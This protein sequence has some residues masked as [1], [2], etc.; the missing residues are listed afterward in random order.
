MKKL[1]LFM[2]ILFSL[3]NIF[4]KDLS[5]N[6]DFNSLEKYLEETVTANHVPG[7]AFVLTNSKNTLFAKTFGQCKNLDQQ[8]FLG[9]ESK[10]FTALCIMQLSEKKLLNLDDDISIYLPDYSFSK[11]VTVKSLLNQVSG[12]DTHM[13]LNN[14]KVTN[15]YGKYEYANINYDLLGKIIET[16][17]GTSYEDYIKKN[18]F[19]PLEMNG[20]IANAD[21]VKNSERLLTGNRNY[22][23]FFITGDA[24]YPTEKSWFHEPAGFITSTPNDYAK[25]LR[26][27]LNNGLSERNQIIA[28]ESSI[29]SMWYDNVEISKNEPARYGMGWNCL[30]ENGT[31]F[32]SHGGQVENY[33][34]Y[35]LVIPQR[36]LAFTFMINGNDHLVM[37]ALMDKTI[38]GLVSILNGG[39]ECKINRF[40]YLVF[41]SILDFFY[42]LIIAFSTFILIKSIRQ[43]KNSFKGSKKNIIHSIIEYIVWPVFLLLLP[44]IIAAT[45]MWVVKSFVPDMFY[46]L[47]AGVVLSLTGLLVRAL[48]EIRIHGINK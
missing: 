9:S 27:Y 37:N 18:V 32:L 7:M 1:V 44:R 43:R 34:T 2:V 31:T 5:S 33:I 17:S 22:F 36:D 21:K 8:F 39:Q 23:G 26:M 15:R 48:S 46:T 40:S 41:H 38:P 25:Y 30:E 10:S 6:I 28:Q 35:M 16:V 24:D 45:P 47:I 20:S 14:V 4:A 29:K 3:S 19:D 11:K 42:F 12:F 13:K